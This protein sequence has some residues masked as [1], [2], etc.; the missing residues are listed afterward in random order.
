MYLGK[1]DVIVIGLGHAG[2]EAFY[3]LSKMGVKTLGVT[4]NIDNIAQ[5]SCNPAIGGL[6]KSQIVFEIAAFGGIMP[7]SRVRR[8]YAIY[9]R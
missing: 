8:H 9:R 6:A 1:Y 5:M 2:C 4:I 3:A 7:D